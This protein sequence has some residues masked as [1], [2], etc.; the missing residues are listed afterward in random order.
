VRVPAREAP[1]KKAWLGVALNEQAL[2]MDVFEDSPAEKA[3]IRAGD[4]I[5]GIDGRPVEDAHLI[6]AVV[7]G[8]RP[9]D[10]ITVKLSRGDETLEV[11]AVVAEKPGE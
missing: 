4:V 10:K 3:G 5:T 9:G 11:E 1:A 2:V 6:I 8:K 7:S